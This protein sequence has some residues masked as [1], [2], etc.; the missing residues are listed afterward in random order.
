MQVV[1]ALAIAAVFWLFWLTH[2]WD[3]FEKIGAILVVFSIMY[4]VRVRYLRKS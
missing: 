1:P 3:K 2:P 4:F